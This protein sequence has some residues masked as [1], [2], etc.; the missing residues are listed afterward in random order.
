MTTLL[1]PDDS[2][3][4]APR[5]RAR[6]PRVVLGVSFLVAI[7]AFFWL[8][9]PE[10][11]RVETL[12][13]YRDELLAEV[14]DHFWR[15]LGLAFLIYAS[16][17]ALSVPGASVLSLA[18]GLVFGRWVGT[19]LIVAAATLGATLVFLAARYLFADKVRER[20]GDR[21]RRVMEGFRRDAASYLLFLR[22]V[23]LFP[24]WLCNLVAALTPVRTRLYVGTTALGILPGSFVFANLGESLGRIESSRQLLS[25][26]VLLALALL[27][28]LALVPVVL[29]K[30]R[31]L[32]PGG[33]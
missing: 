15:T 18:S 4:P 11:L 5:P 23:P 6:A 31:S 1:R 9:G 22:L 3:A 8:G 25:A 30:R 21:G 12:G 17:V 10:I 26:E 28:V 16:V 33:L 27:G 29:R 20:I 24:F 14:R 7:A 13:A 2:A 19:A 32:Q